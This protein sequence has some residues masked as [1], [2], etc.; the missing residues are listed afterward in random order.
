MRYNSWINQVNDSSPTSLTTPSP[1]R[2]LLRPSP[3]SRPPRLDHSLERQPQAVH[4]DQDRQ[5][6]L[7][8]TRPT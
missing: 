1:Q 6:N 7:R 2:P 3:R 4:L 8:I 5:P